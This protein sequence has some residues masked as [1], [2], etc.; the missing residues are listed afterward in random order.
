MR[1]YLTVMS[2]FIIVCGETDRECPSCPGMRL[3]EAL[4]QRITHNRWCH[5]VLRVS[6]DPSLPM[7]HLR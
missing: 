1:T 3:R 4:L 6:K 5:N 7:R 2:T